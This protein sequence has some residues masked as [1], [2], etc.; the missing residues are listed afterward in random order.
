MFSISRYLVMETAGSSF[1]EL[2]RKADP[3]LF[4]EGN[5]DLRIALQMGAQINRA[6]DWIHNLGYVH[7][8]VSVSRVLPRD[9]NH[10]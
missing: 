5:L 3:K 8:D 4:R 6:L 9:S 10:C 1:G 7:R 2:Q